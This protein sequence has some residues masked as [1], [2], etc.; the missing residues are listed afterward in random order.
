MKI[1]NPLLIFLLLIALAAAQATTR[2]TTQSVRLQR[3][4]PGERLER[5]L[6]LTLVPDGSARMV[7]VE[8]AG[9]IK[10]FRPQEHK[11]AGLLLD[12][13]GQVSS[14]G[15]EEGLL[16]VAFHP[17]FEKTRFFYVYYS[18]ASPRRSVISRFTAEQGRLSAKRGSEQV[19]LEVLQPY[20]NH[21]GG[22]LAF[23]PDGYL[24]I[25]LGD[26]GSGGDPLG[27]GQNAGTLLGSIL[28]IDVNRAAGGLPYA[29]PRDNPF[30]NAGDGRRDEIWAYGL[31]NPW[32]FSFDRKTGKLYAADVGQDAVEEIDLIFK[33]ANYGWNV[34]EG[35]RC[36]NPPRRCAPVAMAA[37]I[38]EYRHDLGRS[39][40][41]GYVYRGSAIP[42][43]KGRYLFGDFIS[44]RIWSIPGGMGGMRRP[45]L[46]L[47]SSLAIASFGEDGKGELYIA[48]L[49]GNLFK[50]M[51]KP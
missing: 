14:E 24:Y 15:W 44:G 23:G 35:T 25:G 34:M 17:Q 31:R 13:R 27:N 12:V 39:V 40:T 5:P 6:H 3:I 4:L 11:A 21:N 46:L 32:R 42:A 45:K 48:D 38:S 51:K 9:R 22:Q 1:F 47:K 16:S 49:K 18:A 41:G 37:P 2:V 43:L 33:G 50:I 8:Q 26:G 30:V 20:S 36:F 10:F 7:V 19:L 29:V 28:R